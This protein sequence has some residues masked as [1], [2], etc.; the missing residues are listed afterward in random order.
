MEESTVVAFDQRRVA[1]ATALRMTHYRLM[2][3][4]D[5]QLEVVSSMHSYRLQAAANMSILSN[6]A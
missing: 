5:L 6:K 1:M 2:K 4:L 3:G